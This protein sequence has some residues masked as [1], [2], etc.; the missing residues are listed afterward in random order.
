MPRN[1]VIFS[2]GT[3]QDGGVRP[4]QRLSN[5]YKLYRATRIGPDSPIDP[6]DQ[7]AFY[8]PGLGTDDDVHGWE[9]I[10]RR[11]NKLLGS[12]A[13]RGIG[14]NIADCYEFI[15]NHWSPGDRIF[16]IGFS[17][18]AYT[19][20]CVAQVLSL[21]GVPTHNSGEP[22][23]PFRRFSRMARKVAERAVHR[24]YEHG[25]GHPRG[26]YEAERDTLGLR[27]RQE[28]GSDEN[29]VANAC[30][31]FIGVFD[32]VAALGAKKWKWFGILVLL[33]LSGLV[34]TAMA[35]GIASYLFGFKFWR[36]LVATYVIGWLFV[37]A[38]SF[39]GSVR[40]IDHYPDKSSPRRWRRVY[41]RA[42]NYDR[43][44]SGHVGYARQASAIDEDRAD[45]PRVPW[46]RHTV[47]RQQ[48]PGEPPPVVQLWF[49]GN[50]SDIGGSYPEEESRLSD[51][52]LA[53]MVEEATSIPGPL[54]VDRSRLKTTPNASGVQHS[55][56][57]RVKDQTL[58]WV[59]SW[60][61]AFLREGWPLEH[62]KPEGS[63]VHPSVFER[64]AA[65]A[66]IQT[67]GTAPYRPLNL[68]NDERFA[69]YYSASVSHDPL[70][71]I[72]FN[73]AAQD[74]TFAGPLSALSSNFADLLKGE[75]AAC[76]AVIMLPPN[77]VEEHDEYRDALALRYLDRLIERGGWKALPLTGSD[78][79]DAAKTRK[80]RL[81]I[82]PEEKAAL[83][84][85]RSIGQMTTIMIRADG[86]S[87]ALPSISGQP[88]I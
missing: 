49:A 59:P 38:R 55:E 19:A 80:G 58:W 15:I 5:V 74:G 12:V 41:W 35:V 51:I 75:N 81:V 21:C 43:G 66:V 3:G 36:S 39:W 44:L 70:D 11:L 4:D 79:T 16:I 10:S 82:G 28:F 53:W 68:A 17:R 30:P 52:A 71:L 73:Y 54:I 78:T 1:I 24:V 85:A 65:D 40:Y 34:A 9:K 37:W 64:F 18:G 45:F 13:G 61:P 25:A 8:D 60:A 62:R 77:T 76:A 2:D 20:R 69:P 7:I 46:G 84:L 57:E 87:Q 48:Q 83:A 63:P 72:S 26:T 31:H 23:V 22:H 33:S 14:T 88:G 32:T 67:T 86:K 56:I 47:I 29:G 50:H 27:F 6:Q 42:D